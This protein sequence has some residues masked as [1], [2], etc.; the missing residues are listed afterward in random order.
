[1]VG[2]AHVQQ[3]NHRFEATRIQYAC[4]PDHATHIPENDDRTSLVEGLRRMREHS[5][6]V[7]SVVDSRG[8]LAL[9]TTRQSAKY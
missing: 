1:M 7:I 9:S 2:L 4:R 5:V 3:H 8:G 6:P